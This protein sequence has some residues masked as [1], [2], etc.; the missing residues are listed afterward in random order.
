MYGDLLCEEDQ[1][2][3]P[4]AR[5]LDREFVL[6]PAT[7]LVPDWIHPKTS[8]SIAAHREQLRKETEPPLRPA[9]EF[10]LQSTGTGLTRPMMII[11]SLALLRETLD[12]LRNLGETIGFVPTMGA[13]HRG[14]GSLVSQS[15]AEN[16][17]T[18]LSA[19]KTQEACEAIDHAVDALKTILALTAAA[20]GGPIPPAVAKR[21]DD[22]SVS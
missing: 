18:V 10:A 12:H 15:V 5:M 19:G 17:V 4:H 1:L 8:R 9:M 21:L 6:Q 14:H 13:L 20:G 16:S 3:I 22:A 11:K 2:T 7:D